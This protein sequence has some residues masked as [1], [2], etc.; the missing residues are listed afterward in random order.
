ML[1]LAQWAIES[2]LIPKVVGTIEAMPVP[3]IDDLLS[4]PG[5]SVEMVP[6]EMDVI[7]E[8]VNLFADLELIP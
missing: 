4:A 6:L 7:G 5:T 3:G 1:G 2:H 8:Y